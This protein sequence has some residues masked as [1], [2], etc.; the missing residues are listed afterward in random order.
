MNVLRPLVFAAAILG[1]VPDLPPP[2]LPPAEQK[3]SEPAPETG[4][5]G[6]YE[7]VEPATVTVE[8]EALEAPRAF[9]IAP[10]PELERRYAPRER[11]PLNRVTIPF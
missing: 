5:G 6:P 3:G 10:D 11:A 7:P 4:E 1:G 9:T 8:A 2:A